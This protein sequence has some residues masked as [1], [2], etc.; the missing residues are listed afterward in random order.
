MN[1][2]PKAKKFRVRR[3]AI[4]SDDGAIA[5]RKEEAERA[6][7]ILH[8]QKNASAQSIPIEKLT[9]RQLRMAG[10]LAERKGLKV[11]SDVEAIKAL[12]DR[13]IDPFTTNRLEIVPGQ[14]AATSK[15]VPTKVP[16]PGGVQ[17]SKQ[18]APAIVPESVPSTTVNAKNPLE[19]ANAHRAEQIMQMQRDLAK[20][21]RRKIAALWTEGRVS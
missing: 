13:G 8:G 2:K 9:D 15:P 12:R 16:A 10:R 20:R 4:L 19:A 7:E 14:T 6:A 3:S 11:S 21:R 18:T 1:T 17:S 5:Q